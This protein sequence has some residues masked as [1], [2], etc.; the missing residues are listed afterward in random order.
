M[1]F[2]INAKIN[3]ILAQT[4]L[5]IKDVSQK[6]PVLK[7][8]ANAAGVPVIDENN[9]IRQIVSYYPIV[10]QVYNNSANSSD[11]KNN[12]I[13]LSFSKDF[14]NLTHYYTSTDSDAKYMPLFTVES[15]LDLQNQLLTINLN[16]YA[17]IYIMLIQLS[18]TCSGEL[19]L[20]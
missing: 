11:V 14:S 15:P 9:N 8:A 18:P 4:E 12:Q 1:S 19:V 10:S 13:Q 3:N 6:Q 7:Q 2:N 20:A 5:I 17:T 16:S